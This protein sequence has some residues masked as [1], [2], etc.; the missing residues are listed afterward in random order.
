MFSDSNLPH[1][2]SLFGVALLLLIS[3]AVP[4]YPPEGILLG[5]SSL[6]PRAIGGRSL[7]DSSIDVPLRWPCSSTQ[8]HRHFSRVTLF[9]RGITG[10][11]DS[12]SSIGVSIR[13]SRR[14]NAGPENDLK[15]IGNIS[16]YG[17]RT[18]APRDLSFELDAATRQSVPSAADWHC[19]IDVVFAPY[20]AVSRSTSFGVQSIELWAY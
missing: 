10:A 17:L 19:Q 2:R 3:M 7:A 4:S 11:V 6:E 12:P 15:Q 16:S 20:K 8:G 18:D 1:K 13:F 9:L 5:K 14:G